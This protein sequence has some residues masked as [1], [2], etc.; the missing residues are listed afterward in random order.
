MD[1]VHAL[2]ELPADTDP[3][4]GDKGGTLAWLFPAG[5]LSWP[6]SLIRSKT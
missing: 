6:N 5:S 4:A 1:M 2:G 3:S